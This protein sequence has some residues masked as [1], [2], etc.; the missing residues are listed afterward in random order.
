MKIAKDVKQNPKA[1]FNYISQ[2]TKPKENVT[3][4]INKDGNLTESD[5]EKA[6]VLN[7]FFGEVFTEEDGRDIE[8]SNKSDI[9]L[10]NISITTEDMENKLLK[11]NV[12]KS[13]GPDNL[14]PK[15]L[16][17][18]ASELAYPLKL[19]FDKTLSE[20]RIPT[21]WK[22]AEVRPI[23]KKGDKSTPGNYRPVS[24]TSVCCKIF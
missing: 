15:I 13:C 12:N 18:L 6:E 16:K 3:N 22:L 17:E 20:G 11:L 19:L 5:L 4:L 1:F 14:H 21:K 7:T 8:F 9:I 10:N 2:K 24:L 23:F